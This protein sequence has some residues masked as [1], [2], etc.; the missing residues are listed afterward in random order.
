LL[1][2]LAR[3]EP[4]DLKQEEPEQHSKLMLVALQGYLQQERHS[5]LVLVARPER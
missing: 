1:A 4:L 3:L 2:Q 5:K